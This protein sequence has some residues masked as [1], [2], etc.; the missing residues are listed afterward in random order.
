MQVI[1]QLVSFNPDKRIG[2]TVDRAVKLL[3][4][5]IRQLLREM[6]L[7]IAIVTLPESTA[8]ADHILP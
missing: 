5:N 7:Q 2:Y 3:H 4:F 1:R 8:A 6:L